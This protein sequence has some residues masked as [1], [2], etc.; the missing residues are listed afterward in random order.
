MPAPTNVKT[1]LYCLPYL[2][3]Q[4]FKVRTSLQ[5]VLYNN[6]PDLVICNKG[7]SFYSHVEKTC[8]AARGQIWVHKTSLNLILYIILQNVYPINQF[9]PA[10]FLCLSLARVCIFQLPSVVVFFLAFCGFRWEV[11]AG[12]VDIGGIVDHHCLNFFLL[13]L[14]ENIFQLD[15]IRLNSKFR[16]TVLLW[17]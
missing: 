5:G 9:Y 2:I 17:G 6:A 12:F 10:T 1:L 11:V 4:K 3:H 15:L 7:V 16:E 8:M 14:M 13:F